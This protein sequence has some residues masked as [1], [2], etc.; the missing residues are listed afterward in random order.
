[1]NTINQLDD[2]DMDVSEDDD[3]DTDLVR[4]ILNQPVIDLGNVSDDTDEDPDY[5]PDSHNI[6]D[7]DDNMDQPSTSNHDNT[8]MS[9]KSCGARKTK[10]T[11]DQPPPRKKSKIA[12]FNWKEDHFLPEPLN[13]LSPNYVPVE[14]I[15]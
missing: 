10:R 15:G 6:D 7:S 11:S 9:Q 3:Q 1:M 8:K 14:S 13:L 4:D 5:V 2:S 12:T